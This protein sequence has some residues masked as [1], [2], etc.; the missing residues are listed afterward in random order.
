MKLIQLLDG[1]NYT[2]TIT[3]CEIS[4]VSCDSRKLTDSS[5]FVCIK[6]VQSDGHNFAQ[7][8]LE[9]GVPYIVCERDLGLKNQILVE[10]SHYAYAKMCANMQGN[11]AKDLKFIGVTGTNGKTTVTNIM[12]AV[13]TNMGFKVGLIGTIRNEIGDTVFHTEKTT[14]DAA[15]YQALLAKMV[16]AHCDYVV[17]EV[18]SHALDQCRLADT[19][20]EVGIFTNLTQDHLD[21]HHTME[22]YFLAKKKLF[23]CSDCAVINMD[24]PYG[25]RLMETIPCRYV[26]YSVENPSADFFANEIEINSLGV[27]FQM[28]IGDIASKIHFGTPGM[29]SVKNALAAAAACIQI[30]I[31]VEKVADSITNASHVKGRSEVI[32]T[33]QDFTII[34]DY[35]HT[36]DGLKNILDSINGYKKGRVVALFGCGGDRDNKKRP[37]MGQVAAQNADFL[38]V[39]SDNPRTENPETIIDQV[40][41]GVEKENTPYVRITNRKEAIFYAVQ[42]AQKDDVILLAGKGHE[43]YQVLGTERVHFDE[44]EIVAEALKTLS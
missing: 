43:D 39:T 9:K 29:F 33:G 7:S 31:S 38:I 41:V 1:I 44:R 2:G 34:C 28:K 14:P 21:Y 3:D 23:D 4:D 22:N 42:H 18:S 19:H 10:N 25:K 27:Q 37:I 8:A 32:P 30:G 15:D 20:F 5:V 40:L 6:G 11:P 17:L 26:T 16:E 24:D 35:A 36:P 13:L 12:K